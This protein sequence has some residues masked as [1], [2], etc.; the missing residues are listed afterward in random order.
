VCGKKAKWPL[1]SYFLHLFVIYVMYI[2]YVRKLFFFGMLSQES[3]S[4]SSETSRDIIVSWPGDIGLG[5]R[6]A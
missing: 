1:V 5:I 6:D 2:Y 4:E 3:G